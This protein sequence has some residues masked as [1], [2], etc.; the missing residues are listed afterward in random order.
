MITGIL[1]LCA[2]TAGVYAGPAPTA[3]R[4]ALAARYTDAGITEHFADNE[5][6]P[7]QTVS[8]SLKQFYTFTDDTPLPPYLPVFCFV[9]NTNCLV[10]TR[11][12]K[13]RTAIALLHYTSQLRKRVLSS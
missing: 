4:Q 10:R 9:H 11:H 8:D 6:I 13:I 1:C 12:G 5:L 3:L 2:L 7:F